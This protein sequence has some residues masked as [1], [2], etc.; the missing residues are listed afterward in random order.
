MSE[1]SIVRQM[2]FVALCA[3]T[4]AV[5]LVWGLGQLDATPQPD[6]TGDTIGYEIEQPSWNR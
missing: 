3:I 4:F 1:R 6:T 2:I 5:L